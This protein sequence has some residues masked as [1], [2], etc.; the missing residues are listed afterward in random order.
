ME[1][2]GDPQLRAYVVWVP[3]VSATQNDVP[4][5]T[6]FVADGR[7]MHYWDDEATLLHGYEPVLSISQDAWDIYMIYGPN[8]RWESD[9]PPEPDYWMHQLDL[10]SAPRFDA[11]AFGEKVKSFNER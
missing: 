2:N 7:A 4:N 1:K 11:A 8:A 10:D 5:A 9:A 3:K 6:R